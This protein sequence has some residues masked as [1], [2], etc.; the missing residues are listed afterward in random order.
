MNARECC[1][2]SIKEH[3][4]FPSEETLKQIIQ[5]RQNVVKTGVID[6]DI[7]I[8]MFSW[9]FSQCWHSQCN[10]AIKRCNILIDFQQTHFFIVLIWAWGRK[11]NWKVSHK[12]SSK[13]CYKVDQEKLFKNQVK[14]L[15]SEYYSVYINLKRL[16]TS[17][18]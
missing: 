3:K 7:D 4:G 13:R 14:Y 6:S 2:C 12:G 10:S 15:A 16:W 17:I 1:Y 5:N 18:C 8:Q 11:S 9:L